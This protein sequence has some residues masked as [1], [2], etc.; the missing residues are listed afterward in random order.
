MSEPQSFRD[1]LSPETQERLARIARTHR[2]AVES[3][4]EFAEAFDSSG[5]DAAARELIAASRWGSQAPPRFA[6][7]TLDEIGQPLLDKLNGWHN[8]V[9]RG[10]AENLVL[11]GP[12]GTGKTYAALAVV[13]PLV[14]L[15][16]TLAFWP[17]V[18]LLDALRPSHE[19]LDVYPEAVSADLLVLDDLAAERATEWT[20]ERLYSIV[21]DRWLDE[22][23]TI[24][25]T[26]LAPPELVAAVGERLSSRLLG[27]AT[28]ARLSGHDRRMQ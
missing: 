18:R 4:Q 23:P 10:T 16:R 14:E 19:T 3:A 1:V 24:V 2:A 15:G 17:V 25:T 21:N 6:G 7:A 5:H 26:N 12:V 11:T 9:L 8:S 22:R 27:G 28:I 13:R 20:A